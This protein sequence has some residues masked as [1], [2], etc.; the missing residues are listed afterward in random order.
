MGCSTGQEQPGIPKS[1]KNEKSTTGETPPPSA[2]TQHTA[3]VENLNNPRGDLTPHLKPGNWSWEFPRSQLVRAGGSASTQGCSGT[4]PARSQGWVWWAWL[5]QH[6]RVPTLS[7][8]L[9]PPYLRGVPSAPSRVP[10]E[11]P[12]HL[13]GCGVSRSLINAQLSRFDA[14]RR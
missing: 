4:H 3:G 1:W 13:K 10:Q 9:S 6:S 7:P 14:S 8:G 12:R 5:L 2:P 11:S